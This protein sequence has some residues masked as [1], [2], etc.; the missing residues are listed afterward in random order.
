MRRQ[1][2]L[3]TS[4][5]GDKGGLRPRRQRRLKTLYECLSDSEIC[6]RSFDKK[7]IPDVLQMQRF[8]KS[9]T[10]SSKTW[11]HLIKLT[12]FVSN[13]CSINEWWEFG[14]WLLRLISFYAEWSN[15]TGSNNL[16]IKKWLWNTE[17]HS[18]SRAD[19]LQHCKQQCT[20]Y[21]CIGILNAAHL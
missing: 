16:E 1:R 15:P 10:N 21:A 19:Y 3:K 6:L 4:I 7:R 20:H 11:R 8:L 9:W 14:A 17:Y 13:L 12:C 2:R 5:W 18:T